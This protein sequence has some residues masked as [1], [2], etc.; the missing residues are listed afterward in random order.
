[1]LHEPPLQNLEWH[2]IRWNNLNQVPVLTNVH[3]TNAIQKLQVLSPYSNGAPPPSSSCVFC[4]M[5]AALF[6]ALSW[7]VTFVYSSLPLRPC[8]Q[9]SQTFVL[10]LIAPIQKYLILPISSNTCSYSWVNMFHTDLPLGTNASSIMNKGKDT[11]GC[12]PSRGWG[13]SFKS[14]THKAPFLQL[15]LPLH[16][17]RPSSNHEALSMFCQACIC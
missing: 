17:K 6:A 8:L 13:A 5:L 9:S 7:N 3:I 15:S 16:Q 14:T 2:L 10:A 4:F 12:R 11:G 1:M